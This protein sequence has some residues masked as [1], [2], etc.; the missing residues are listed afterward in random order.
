MLLVNTQT[1][2]ICSFTGRIPLHFKCIQMKANQIIYRDISDHPIQISVSYR[3]GCE[4][5]CTTSQC[6]ARMCGVPGDNFVGKTEM[7]HRHRQQEEWR[8][9]V[10]RGLVWQ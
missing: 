1:F 4:L 8:K 3:A 10:V 6:V 5:R 2:P 7:C 9:R